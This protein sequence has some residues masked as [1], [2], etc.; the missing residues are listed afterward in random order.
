MSI[1]PLND[2]FPKCKIFSFLMKFRREIWILV[3]IFALT[4]FIWYVKIIQYDSIFG[5]FTDS[6]TWNYKGLIFWGM[7]ALIISIPLLLT[8]NWIFVKLL[9]K[10][11]KYLQKWAYFMFPLVWIHIFMIEKDMWPL[12]VITAWFILFSIA[13]IKNKYSNKTI[14]NWPKW[15]CVPCWYIYEENIWDIDSWIVPWTRFEDIPSDWICPVCGVGKSDFIL[16]EKKIELIEGKIISKEYLTDDV[17]ELRLMFEKELEYISGQFQN[18]IFKD[19]KGEFNRSYSIA[20]KTWNKF[21]FL[22]KLT[23][24]WRASNVL[25]GLKFADKIKV[26]NIWGNFKLQ[27]TTNPKIFIATWTWLAPIYSMIN[28]TSPDVNKRLY[29]WVSKKRDMFYEEKL[30]KIKNLEVNLYLSREEA[31]GYN[32][33]RVNLDEIVLDEKTEVYIC[34]NPIMVNEKVDY[35]TKKLWSANVFYERF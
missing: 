5:I 27:N 32:F 20:N 6:N 9:W 13:F 16:L 7:L 23:P 31:R 8:S 22:I 4:H 24:N 21:T 1:R 19:E 34:W 28:S 14:S 17:I 18:L 11:W 29:F 25:D 35:F 10:N 15:L 2:I 3:W 26:W 12:V 30:K 33:W